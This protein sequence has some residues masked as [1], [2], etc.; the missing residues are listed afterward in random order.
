MNVVL[1]VDIGGSGIKGALVDV[2]TGQIISERFKKSTPQPSTPEAMALVV[3]ELVQHFD[4]K[5]PIGCGF[6]APIKNGVAKAA[7]NI[8]PSWKGTNVVKTFQDATGCEVRVIN[9][10]DAAG[11]AEVAFGAA[12]GV[13]G[14]VILITIGTGIGTALF[15][16]GK[17]VPNSELGHVIVNGKV[18]DGYVSSRAR[19]LENLEIPKWAKRFNKYLFR[20]GFLLSPDL[21][22]I[23]GGVSKNFEEYAQFFDVDFTVVPAHF[24][25]KAGII[26]AACQYKH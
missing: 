22:V 6:P 21:V 23:G 17:L 15:L 26:G 1:G 12:K 24:R 4:W 16:D 25:N 10:A 7:T 19:D 20:I 14:V 8:D 18:A 5:G 13:I 9:D 3:K 2:D 11:L